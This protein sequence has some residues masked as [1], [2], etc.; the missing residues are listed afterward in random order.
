M[1]VQRETRVRTTDSMARLFTGHSRSGFKKPSMSTSLIFIL[2]NFCGGLQMTE[3]TSQDQVRFLLLRMYDQRAQPKQNE[4]LHAAPHQ[5][6]YCPDGSLQGIRRKTAPLYPSLS[7]RTENSSSSPAQHSQWRISLLLLPFL[8][9]PG[10]ASLLFL[11]HRLSPLQLPA[12][13]PSL[14]RKS[15]RC[16]LHKIHKN[17]LFLILQIP[18]LPNKDLKELY[19]QW[20]KP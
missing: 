3:L 9:F 12:H 6:Q 20:I 7:S 4:N 11:P 14:F 2:V 18:V 17:K 19:K 5:K 15:L 13:N 8:I 1:D 16:T 10:S